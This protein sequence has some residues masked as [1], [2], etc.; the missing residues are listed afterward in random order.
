V[1]RALYAALRGD[2]DGD[3]EMSDLGAASEPLHGGEESMRQQM[4]ETSDGRW[5]GWRKIMSKCSRIS[6]ALIAVAIVTPASALPIS[7]NTIRKECGLANGVYSTGLFYNKAT[8]KNDRSS[9]CAYPDINGDW[10]TDYY[11][12]GEYQFTSP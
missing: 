5:L 11:K 8:K 4:A 10:H 1:C 12:N 7:E 9:L 2:C 3:H 6:A